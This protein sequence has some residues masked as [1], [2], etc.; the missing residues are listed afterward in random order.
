MNYQHQ[1]G[2]MH[3][4]FFTIAAGLL[5]FIC[6]PAPAAII[7]YQSQA[8]FNAAIAGW[9]STSTNF[10]ST[11][12]GTMYA[13]GTGP[14]GSG[15]TF[16]LSGP[17]APALQP[18]VSDQF[19]TTSGTKY[20]GLN[21]ADTAF[22]VGDFLTINFG[23]AVQAFGL[24]I[25][26]GGDLL[27]GDISLD[28]GANSI[29]NAA[30]AEFGDGNGSYAYFLGF[31]S[32]DASTFNSVTLRYTSLQPPALLPIALDDMVLASNDGD[33]PIPVPATTPLILMGLLL[34]YLNVRRKS[35]SRHTF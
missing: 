28:T 12:T 14:S 5:F 9:S 20:L 32:N 23:T 24:F 13:P 26:G 27:G 7:G 4:T 21:N 30:S 19:W 29:F 1:C 16:T 18:T 6:S 2:N 34:I 10:D 31:V 35:I 22:Q 17:D 25:I 33:T 3:N 11:S 15:M 8:G